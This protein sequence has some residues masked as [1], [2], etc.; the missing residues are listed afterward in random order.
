MNVPKKSGKTILRKNLRIL[1][2]LIGAI[3]VWRGIWNTV[4]RYLFPLHPEIGDIV[5]IILGVIILL[6]D[7]NLL[8]ELD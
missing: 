8:D 4:D 2:G 3:L 5:G 1:F 7:N 6:V